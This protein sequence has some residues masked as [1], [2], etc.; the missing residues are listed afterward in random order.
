MKYRFID[1]EKPHHAVSRLCRA[2]GVTRAAYYAWRKRGMSARQEHDDALKDWIEYFFECSRRIYG[3]P[4]IHADFVLGLGVRVGRKRIARLM[5][6]LDIIGLSKGHGKRPAPKMPPECEAAPDLVK[7]LF[8]A[9]APNLFWSADITYLRTREGW[10]YLALVMDVFSRRIIG[11]SMAERLHADIVV[12]AVCMAL[13]RRDPPPGLIHH[14]DRGAQYRSL[15]FGKT[16][17]AS[18]VAASMGSRGDA[19]DNAITE[20]VMSTIKNELVEREVFESKD[21]ARLAVFDYIECFYNSY[22]RHS[23]LG[24]L[25]PIEFEEMMGQAAPAA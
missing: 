6:E 10:L 5:R 18:G 25:N 22:R 2:L 21:I 9:N 17:A 23:S 13:T 1:Q 20:S 24:Q 8:T 19:Y 16:L 15:L 11:W 7:R 12:D 14:S 3:A 4:R